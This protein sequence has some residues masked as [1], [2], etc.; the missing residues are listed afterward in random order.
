MFLR[1]LSKVL[2]NIIKRS[3]GSGSKGTSKYVAEGV[4]YGLHFLIF[5]LD[6][7]NDAS[8]L[9]LMSC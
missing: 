6:A 7:S 3:I 1:F 2:V 9:G 4:M 5:H 8:L